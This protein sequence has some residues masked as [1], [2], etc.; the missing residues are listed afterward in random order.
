MPRAE[1]RKT[2]GEAIPVVPPQMQAL[3]PAPA[4]DEGQRI[5]LSS[6]L[7]GLH[8]SWFPLPSSCVLY[9]STPGMSRPC[10][11][12]AEHESFFYHEERGGHEGLKRASCEPIQGW[13]HVSIGPRRKWIQH[14]LTLL[15]FL[16]NLRGD[17]QASSVKRALDASGSGT[18]DRAIRPEKKGLTPSTRVGGVREEAHPSTKGWS[19]LLSSVT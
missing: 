11:T 3:E 19:G 9:C 7:R 10:G 13:T 8:S 17:P 18:L 16:L 12:K 6:F 5:G 4:F 14:P 1:G 15:P 2:A